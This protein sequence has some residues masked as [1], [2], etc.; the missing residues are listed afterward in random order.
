M[1]RVGV[2]IV[3]AGVISEQYLRNL[4]AFPDVEVLFVAD[5]DAARAADRAAAFGI[6]TS[7][8]VEQLLADDRVEIVV[9]LTVPVAHVEVGVAALEAGKHV[10]IEKPP[11]AELQRFAPRD[12]RSAAAASR[13]VESSVGSGDSSGRTSNG[14]SVQAS[15]TASQPRSRRR[16]ITS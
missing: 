5:L 7:G 13:R 3:G 8:G 4:C 2:G 15:A 9:N 6:P 11:A 16:A 10:W 1:S 14:I 12:S